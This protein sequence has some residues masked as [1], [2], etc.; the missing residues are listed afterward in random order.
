MTTFKL[1]TSGA[2]IPLNLHGE[3]APHLAAIWEDL[4]PFVQGYVEALLRPAYEP[5]VFIDAFHFT[6]LAHE[7]LARIKE[8]CERFTVLYGEWPLPEHGRGFWIGRQKDKHSPEFEPLTL[9]LGDDG[10]IY[11]RD[12]A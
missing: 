9:Y 8:D 5:G 6:D 4:D 11:L 10:L 2:I 3:Q 1:D 12:A 7:T